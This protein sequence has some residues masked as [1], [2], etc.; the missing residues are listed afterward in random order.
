ML[1]IGIGYIGGWQADIRDWFGGTNWA[2]LAFGGILVVAF[3]L[4]NWVWFSLAAWFRS[5]GKK[6]LDAAA[7]KEGPPALPLTLTVERSEGRIASYYRF[8]VHN[9]TDHP[10]TKVYGKYRSYRAINR[11][12][13]RLVTKLPF[14]GQDLPWDDTRSGTS[15][16]VDIGAHS[17]EDLLFGFQSVRSFRHYGPNKKPAHTLNGGTYEFI[18]EIGSK[19]SGTPI[20]RRVRVEF[21]GLNDFAVEITP[22]PPDTESDSLK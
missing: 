13:W 18:L 2:P 8:R 3:V 1:T 21:S 20:S 22:P 12:F 10:V 14:D 11:P 4:I 19:T 6:K 16:T 17:S 7:A 9:P 5:K 15:T